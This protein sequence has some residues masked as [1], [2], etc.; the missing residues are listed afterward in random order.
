MAQ[1]SFREQFGDLARKKGVQE[2]LIP[3]WTNW[4][5]AWGKYLSPRKFV[6]AGES[7]VEAFLQDLAD[8]GK[9]GWQIEQAEAALKL[10][11]QSRYPAP[12]SADWKVRQPLAAATASPERR[13]PLDEE[14]LRARHQGKSDRG[15]LPPRFAPFIDEIR[16]AVR[17]RH[18]SYRTEQ[19]YVGWITRFLAYAA[20]EKRQDLHPSQA[21]DYLDY[22]S[23]VRRV[24]SATQNQAFNSLLF[25][26]RSVLEMDF[27]RIEG[28]Q[29]AEQ[30]RRVPVVLSR[31]E[32]A[33]LFEALPDSCRLPVRLFYGAGLRLMEGLRLRIQDIDLELMQIVVRRGK[34]GKDRIA[35]LP[36]SLVEE[37]REQI[38]KVRAI[39][40]ADLAK[41]Y[42]DVEL[43]DGVALKYGGRAREW[44]WQYVFP[45]PGF[46]VDPRTGRTGRHHLHE[47]NIQRAV[48]QAAR[49]AGIAKTV[50]PHIM[51]H[52]FATH[53]LEDGADI[54][55]VQELL[56]HS[57]VST[58]MIYTHVLNRPGLAVRSPLDR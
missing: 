13:P 55:T 22:L 19:T 41:G 46:S 29:R 57:D 26:F 52:S 48:R 15:E 40:E 42:G 53:L 11:H 35:P 37:L 58:T 50:T 44:G 25:L 38:T 31:A 47:V 28:V 49:E 4:V 33:R 3:F 43:P 45:A 7:D 27:G 6:D 32:L 10:L 9:A 51:R 56:G 8:Q 1:S 18:Y 20:P 21:K 24:S 30:R 34:G 17:A 2:S 23:V 54:R 12:W 36:V 16:A 5:M 14:F 39:H